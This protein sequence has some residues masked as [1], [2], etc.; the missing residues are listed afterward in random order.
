MSKEKKKM[1]R[2]AQIKKIKDNDLLEF[3][4]RSNEAQKP[5][6]M[7][8]DDRRVKMFLRS[9]SWKVTAGELDKGMTDHDKPS[10]GV[11]K[12]APA[13]GNQS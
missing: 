3:T 13:G 9:P 10:L 8:K 11:K 1:T 5:V 7:E 2:D 12:Q 6:V 4:H